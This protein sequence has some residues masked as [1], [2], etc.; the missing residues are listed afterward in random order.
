M[1]RFC[2]VG[3]LVVQNMKVFPWLLLL[4]FQAICLT[5]WPAA[6]LTES[7]YRD[8]FKD[9]GFPTWTWTVLASKEWFPVFPVPWL[10]YA[11]ALTRRHEVSVPA[12]LIFAG[13]LCL[14]CC[15]FLCWV[16]SGLLMPYYATHIFVY[17]RTVIGK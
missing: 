15:L 12:V 3:V 8:Q 6:G 5:C 7:V 14:G 13:T 16:V 17:V 1:D 11:I 2:W 10:I 9:T 4:S